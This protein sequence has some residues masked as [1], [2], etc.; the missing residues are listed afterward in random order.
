MSQRGIFYNLVLVSKDDA[1]YVLVAL[2]RLSEGG[3]V[4]PTTGEGELDTFSTGK[5]IKASS[6]GKLLGNWVSH[7]WESCQKEAGCHLSGKVMRGG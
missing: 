1:T 3:Q 6:L 7:L 4:C 5:S 2:V